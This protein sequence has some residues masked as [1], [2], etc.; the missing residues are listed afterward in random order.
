MDCFKDEQTADLFLEINPNI[1]E[2]AKEQQDL[3]VEAT[4]QEKKVMVKQEKYGH[5]DVFESEQPKRKGRGRPKM[6]KPSPKP[7][8]EN[9]TQEQTHIPQ[10]KEA[11]EQQQP[12]ENEIIE[13][14][15]LP[16]TYREKKKL[17]RQ[18][19]KEEEKERKRIEKE[20][21]REIMKEKNRQKARERYHRLREEKQ[22]KI[23]EEEKAIPKQIVEETKKNLNSFQKRDLNTKLNSPNDMDFAT[24]TN[25]MLKYEDLKTKFYKQKEEEERQ[26]QQQQ[27][28][29]FPDNYPVSLIYGNRKKKRNNIF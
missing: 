6:S 14:Q 24:F 2:I 9:T 26:K 7:T 8:V 21:H 15:A 16:M 1:D 10:Q 17:E 18:K 20:K 13:E 25:Y 11:E 3:N 22:Q 5:E 29:P 27:Q 23:Q 28:S 12:L 19:I 4:V